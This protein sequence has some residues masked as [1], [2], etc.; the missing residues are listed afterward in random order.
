MFS[1]ERPI[2]LYRCAR[3]D[4][5]KDYRPLDMDPPFVACFIDLATTLVEQALQGRVHTMY[6]K[7]SSSFR[8]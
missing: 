7:L 8:G 1:S 2:L 5:L 6:A 3:I 4:Q